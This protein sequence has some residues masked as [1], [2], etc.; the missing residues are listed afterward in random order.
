VLVKKLSSG[1]VVGY[2][3][4][5]LV[6]CGG[7]ES[8]SITP[9][10]V[11]G[12][13][14]YEDWQYGPNG[15]T[16]SVAWK[17]IR[18]AVVDLVDE[19]GNI[20]DSTTGSATGEYRVTG[21]G[22]GLYIRVLAQTGDMFPIDLTIKNYS[23]SVY[24]ATVNV[25]GGQSNVNV[26]L[27]IRD[28]DT[29]GGAFNMLDALTTAAQFTQS[30][31]TMVMPP[32]SVYWQRGTSQYGTYYCFTDMLLSMCPQG[33]GMYVSGGFGNSGGDIDHYDDDVLWHEFSHYLEESLNID[34]SPGGPHQLT[35]N[36]LDLRLAWSEGWGNYFSIA[37]KS[38]LSGSSPDLLS[39]TTDT[40]ST[41]YIDVVGSLNNSDVSIAINIDNPGLCGIED[42][43]VYSS[44]EVAI[45]KVLSQLRQLYGMQAVWDVYES[46]LT[47]L[48]GQFVNLE[49]FWDGFLTQTQPDNGQLAILQGIY[50]E[51]R[52][53]Y[54]ED[55][56]EAADDASPSAM[57][58]TSVC[59]TAPCETEE[60]FFYRAGG[61]ID[62]D[63][64]GF[65]AQ[66][67]KS[68]RIET[69]DLKNG[70]DTYLYLMNESGETLLDGGGNPLENDDRG[71]D[72]GECINDGLS[73]S[74]QIEFTAQA[75]GTYYIKIVTSSE[76]TD[77]AGRYGTYSLQVSELN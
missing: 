18:Y 72:C 28:S 35:Q 53:Y 64:V 6:G 58:E 47:G 44:N 10:T 1:F 19:S 51:R 75:G 21:T 11:S 40:E 41:Y 25:D 13:L 43:Y 39:T 8:S 42:C 73:F 15:Y 30:Y 34:D 68:Y 12:V 65:T 22:S 57:R 24:S 67:G 9:T 71:D 5:W 29:T 54:Q 55:G 46:Y 52:I 56:Y 50:N 62:V 61:N 77:G 4:L 37:V 74:S 49:S 3:L 69:L 17:A 20:L 70:A 16:G 60:H 2:L 45:A 14:R 32:L 63:V 33:G 48:N 66:A 7:N 59:A 38:W 31:S 36:T 26:N 23:G 27:D 76:A